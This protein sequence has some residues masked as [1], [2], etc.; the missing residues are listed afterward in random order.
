MK[1]R[2]A[3]VVQ[4]V[5]EHS[6]RLESTAEGMSTHLEGCG[7]HVGKK[8]CNDPGPRDPDC[9]C[10]VC[11]GALFDCIRCGQAEGTLEEQCPSGCVEA[12][13]MSV[14]RKTQAPRIRFIPYDTTPLVQIE[15]ME[16]QGVDVKGAIVKLAPMM[17]ARERDSFDGAGMAKRLRD[18]GAI[19]VQ[20][21]PVVLPDDVK[22]DAERKVARAKSPEEAIRAYFAELKGVPEDERKEAEALTLELARQARDGMR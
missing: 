1:R 15:T 22:P 14:A 8:H 16:H 4:P 13:L 21:A 18:S 17:R 11:D 19:A 12:C 2:G 10:G 6:K 9:Q 3:P 7:Q 20:L 5:E